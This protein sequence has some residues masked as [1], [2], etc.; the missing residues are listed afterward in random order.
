MDGQGDL[1][2]ELSLAM[3]QCKQC[4]AT[5]TS[6]YGYNFNHWDTLH[7][8]TGPGECADMRHYRSAYI[9]E[10]HSLQNWDSWYTKYPPDSPGY[11]A[12]KAGW[13]MGLDRLAARCRLLY[14]RIGT[15]WMDR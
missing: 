8:V 13:A 3:K 11:D 10:R 6:E 14:R 15:P 9:G 1:L 7:A 5:T 12:A 2:D 4:G